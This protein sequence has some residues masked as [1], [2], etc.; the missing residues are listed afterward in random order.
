VFR[1]EIFGLQTPL[2]SSNVLGGQ[3]LARL[4]GST[5]A[6][7][8]TGAS[9]GIRLG[10]ALGVRRICCSG[11]T[12]CSALLSLA[13]RI[14]QSGQDSAQGHAPGFGQSI[15]LPIRAA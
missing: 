4:G 8:G 1:R 7:F 2:C 9:Q 13:L 6:L 5:S 3:Q 10:G 14:H 12:T 11:R 15:R